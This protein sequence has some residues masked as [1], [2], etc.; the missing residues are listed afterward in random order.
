V[1]ETKSLFH[2]SFKCTIVKENL[3]FYKDNIQIPIAGEYFTYIFTAGKTVTLTLQ[4]NRKNGL[5]IRDGGK[6]E[7]KYES[8]NIVKTYQKLVDVFNFCSSLDGI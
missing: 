2:F 1:L 7:C 4:S 8:G 3:K 5:E 6:Y